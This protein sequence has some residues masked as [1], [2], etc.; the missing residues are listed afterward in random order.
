[1]AVAA[2]LY[3]FALREQTPLNSNYA[4]KSQEPDKRRLLSFL[5]AGLC[6]AFS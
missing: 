1:M 4:N 5:L 3:F 2:A 6:A